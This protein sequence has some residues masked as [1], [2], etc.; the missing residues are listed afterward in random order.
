MAA[1]PGTAPGPHPPEASPPVGVRIA[2]VGVGRMG[3]AHLAALERTGRLRAVAI[4]DPSPTARAAVDGRAVAA[5]ESISELVA[6]RHV[7]AA[8]V[9]S[10]TPSHLATVRALAGAGIHVLAEKPCGSRA[11]EAR[12]AGQAAERANVVLQVG[13]WKR[14]V[15]SL[16]DLRD[17]ID[18][19]EL[20]EISVV[21]CFQ[22]DERPPSPLFRAVSGG[23]IVDMAVHEFDLMRWLTGQEV[24]ALAGHAASVAFDPIIE[25][26]PECVALVAK[27]S[28]GAVGIVSVGRRFVEG[29]AHR[30][31]V[32]GTGGAADVPYVWPPHE[33][34]GF[35][36][37]LVAQAEAF[38][39]AVQ[40]GM[41]TG[42]SAH[43]AAAALEAASLAT[44]S[45]MDR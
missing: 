25:T 22:W 42:A 16:R 7:D 28:G 43:D 6:A 33:E 2:I 31:Q 27:L 44:P 19:G 38:G 36:G 20:G 21:S 4:V 40:G 14:F 5:Y 8:I 10:P 23:P 12:Q 1:I 17:Q 15:A 35:L 9:A 26:D 39:D 29:D 45:I 30:V 24:V 3:R 34:E 11:D 18:R 32:I 41:M 37:A 13:Y